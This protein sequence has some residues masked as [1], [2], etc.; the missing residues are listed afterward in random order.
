MLGRKVLIQRIG[1]SSDKS[2]DM[3][4]VLVRTSPSY[5]SS[6]LSSLLGISKDDTCEILVLYG[7]ESTLHCLQL[8]S[9][10]VD[11]LYVCFRSVLLTPLAPL[12]SCSLPHPLLVDVATC[13]ACRGGRCPRH[14]V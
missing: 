14:C 6:A 11:S 8:G 13:L 12:W 7:M 5:S 3:V 2:S 1:A 10:V 9:L 4:K